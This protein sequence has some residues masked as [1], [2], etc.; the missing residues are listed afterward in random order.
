MSVTLTV[1]L[2]NKLGRNGISVNTRGSLGGPRKLD[3]DISVIIFCVCEFIAPSGN[4]FRA[5]N[6]YTIKVNVR[7]IFFNL[8]YD[9]GIF[10]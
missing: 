4:Y 6:I 3:T 9:R 1:R 5:L 10:I 8:S 2:S 7:A